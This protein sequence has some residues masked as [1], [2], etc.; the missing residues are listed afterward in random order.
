MLLTGCG[1]GPSKPTLPP[2]V[3][4]SPEEQARAA[5]SLEALPRES[6]LRRMID[7]YGTLRAMIRAAKTGEAD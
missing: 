2:L 1:G 7:D 5:D 4:Y 6:V 3:V